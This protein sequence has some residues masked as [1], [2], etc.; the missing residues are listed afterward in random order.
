[1]QSEHCGHSGVYAFHQTPHNQ[2]H[3]QQR[4][5]LSR[6]LINCQGGRTKAHE[7]SATHS[8]ER[9]QQKPARWGNAANRIPHPDRPPGDRQDIT[10]SDE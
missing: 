2:S 5:W 3:N 4:A 1:M 8:G 6:E 9:A 7:G 10:L